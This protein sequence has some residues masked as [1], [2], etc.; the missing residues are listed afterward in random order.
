MWAKLVFAV[1]A[2]YILGAAAW[3]ISAGV[4]RPKEGG[5]LLNVACDPTRELWRDLNAAF[6]REHDEKHGTRLSVLQA[7]GGSGSQA[8]AVVDGLE[9]DVI[10]LA[11]WTDT[12]AVRK[13]GLINPGWEDRLPNRSLPYTSTIV[14]VVRNGNPKGVRDWADLARDDVAV[15]TPNPKT[16]GNGRWSFLAL[17][18]SVVWRGGTDARAREFVRGVYTRVPV[19]DPAARGATMTFAQKGIGDVHLTWENE[20]RLEVA[21]AGGALQVVYPGRPGEKP[22]SVLAEPHVAVVDRN[23]DRKGTRAAAEAYMAFLYTPPAQEV[24]ARHHHRPT[25][26]AVFARHRDHFPDMDLRRATTLVPSGKWDDIQ[27]TYFAEGAEF[28]RLYSAKAK[29]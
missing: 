15:V 7:H 20:A 13:A 4:V 5:E 2:A 24:I 3:V 17:W 18:G 11:L 6:V 23:V 19:L 14:F 29:N 16:S 25:D 27:K 21:E 1:A 12:D 28:D 10:T 9:A 22:L 8:R 26:P